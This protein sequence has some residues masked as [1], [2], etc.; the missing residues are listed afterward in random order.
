ML[1]DKCGA[2]LGDRAAPSPVFCRKCDDH[3][4]D[5]ALAAGIY[6]NA[7]AASILNLKKVPHMPRR[8]T[9]AL[10]DRAVG[11]INVDVIVPVPLSRQR[12]H[13]RGFNQAD[14]IARELARVTGHKV[15][16][17]SLG[18]KLHTAAHRIGMDHRA[19]ELSVINA[20]EVIRPKLIEGKA[21]LLVD[22]VFTSGSTASACAHVLK[23]KG[24]CR[25]D[26]FTLARAV[27][28]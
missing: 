19:R 10:A 14:I 6:E 27:M 26:V 13:E 9:A 20:F 23:K 22:D 15:D 18:R 3:H 4:Y 24:A 11:K 5:A 16:S 2:L 12:Q 17:A 7:L 28:R 8:L 25:V 1:C 21:I